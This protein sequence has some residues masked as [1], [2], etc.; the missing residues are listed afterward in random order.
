MG[1]P[2]VGIHGVY[3]D[4]QLIENVREELQRLAP[5]WEAGLDVCFRNKRRRAK[6][7]R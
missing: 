3:V 7:R 6:S 5:F 4:R 2:V 1:S